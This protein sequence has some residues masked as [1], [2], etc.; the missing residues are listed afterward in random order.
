[1]SLPRRQSVVLT[2]LYANRAYTTTA[3]SVTLL[4]TRQEPVS[5][6][7]HGP[8]LFLLSLLNHLAVCGA[9][10]EVPL[11]R[12]WPVAPPFL[13]MDFPSHGTLDVQAV[14]QALSR[15][16]HRLVQVNVVESQ[17]LLRLGSVKDVG[18]RVDLIALRGVTLRVRL[19]VREV[20]R[21]R[22]G[23]VSVSCA[24]VV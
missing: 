18:V 10:T 12:T 22:L 9:G 15:V 5:L 2:F 1:M 21:E 3:S 7:L 6:V 16:V 20:L 23:C 4:T 17:H 24:G 19:A 8:N 13:S 11:N 14:D